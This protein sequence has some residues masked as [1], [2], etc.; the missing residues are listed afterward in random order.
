[1]R[2]ASYYEAAARRLAHAVAN[3]ITIDGTFKAFDIEMQGLSPEEKDKLL[4]LASK[5]SQEDKNTSNHFIYEENGDGQFSIE[6]DIIKLKSDT[7]H[8]RSTGQSRLK[9]GSAATDEESEQD[10]NKTNQQITDRDADREKF[11]EQ[12]I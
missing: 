12:Q 2:D 8:R 5:Y 10:L 6:D 3:R 11:P 7:L 1:M 4:I 9:P